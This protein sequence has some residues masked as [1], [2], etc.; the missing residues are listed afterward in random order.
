MDSLK[1][2]LGV[3]HMILI[4]IESDSSLSGFIEGRVIGASYGINQR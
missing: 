1:A 2:V 4:N 3:L